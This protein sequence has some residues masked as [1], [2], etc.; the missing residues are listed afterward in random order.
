LAL[1]AAGNLLIADTYNSR[2]RIVNATTGTISTVVTTP[3]SYMPRNVAIDPEGSIYYSALAEDCFYISKTGSI[4]K[5]DVL[6]NVTEVVSGL[7]CPM[8][9]ALHPDTNDLY[10]A[11]YGN[12][13]EPHGA[14]YLVN[15]G[16][17][18]AH[19]LP[20]LTFFE[21]PTDVTFGGGQLHISGTPWV[22]KQDEQGNTTILAYSGC[23]TKPNCVGILGYNGQALPEGLQA[24]TE[25]TAVIFN[26]PFGI[27]L[28]A[29][30]SLLLA[31]HSGSRVFKVQV[32]TGNVSVVL[33]YGQDRQWWPDSLY[34]N[35]PPRTQIE[36]PRG[37]VVAPDGTL[38]VAVDS[39]VLKLWC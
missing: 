14:A 37:M 2:I 39:R 30:G 1:D 21:A 34:P 24:I 35:D 28:D 6:G 9:I 20:T 36:N 26:A 25:D 32:N 33:G 38:Y 22:L 3:G 15:A 10:I 19:V 23:H 16:T 11:A 5:R 7:P 17:Q 13:L 12:S 8:G 27:A 29:Q 18:E 4:Y 31:S